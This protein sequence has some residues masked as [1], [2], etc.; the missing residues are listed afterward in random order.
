MPGLKGAQ[1]VQELRKRSKASIY[2]MSGSDLPEDLKAAVDGHLS[3][4][5]GPQAVQ[6][7]IEQHHPEAANAIGSDAPVVSAE[8]LAQL[9]GMMPE[10]AVRE[11]YA[12]VVADLEK[13][14]NAIRRAMG[15]R[16]TDE[17]RRIGHSIKGGCGMAGAMQAAHLGSML[18]TRGDHLD[19]VH[20]I[21][22][23][24]KTA[25]LNLRRMLDTEFPA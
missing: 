14:S 8:V 19:N 24:L 3:K 16:D 21:L 25:R 1:L 9:R 22:Q 20:A 7:L 11:I 15:A 17:I 10:A 13:R 23:E 6:Q 4:P 2:A 12:A 5:F 18:E